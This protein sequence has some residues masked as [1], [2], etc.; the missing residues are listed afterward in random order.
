MPSGVM[1]TRVTRALMARLTID[2]GRRMDDYL[3]V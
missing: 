2:G 1:G 3:G